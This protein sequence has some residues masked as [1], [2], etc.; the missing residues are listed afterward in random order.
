MDIYAGFLDDSDITQSKNFPQHSCNIT[1]AGML[2]SKKEKLSK[3]EQKYAFLTLLDQGGIFEVS[4]F[5]DLFSRVE[6]ILDI[7]RPLLIEAQLKAEA[8]TTKLLGVSVQDIDLIMRN[9]K[10]YLYMDEM[11]NLDSVKNIIEGI[12][13]GAN[14]ISFIITKKNGKKI[15]IE[16]KYKKNL[17]IEKR[18]ML[19]SIQGIRL[20][21]SLKASAASSSD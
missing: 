15:E 8:E 4:I 18:G 20:G 11:V 21:S 3:N 5:P 2:I 12:D 19:L 17:S 16:T 10:V 1:V 13:D 9:S 6:G 14:A 7:G